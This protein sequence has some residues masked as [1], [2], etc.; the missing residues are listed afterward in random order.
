MIRLIIQY[1]DDKGYKDVSRT[2][3]AQSG[4]EL[5]SASLRIFE[6]ILLEGNFSKAEMMVRGLPMKE[7]VE[8][9]FAHVEYLIKRERFMETLMIE[10]NY[11][12][13]VK[14]LRNDIFA[15]VE[16]DDGSASASSAGSDGYTTFNDELKLLSSLLLSQQDDMLCKAGWM[17]ECAESRRKLLENVSCFVSCDHILPPHRLEHLVSQ[18]VSFQRQNNMFYIPQ[19]VNTIS[20]YQDLKS[21]SSWFPS[22]VVREL[23]HHTNEVWFVKFSNSGRYLCSTSLDCQVLIYDVENDFQ[24]VQQLVGSEKAV[25]YASWSPDDSLILTC[26]LDL[27]IRMWDAASGEIVKTLNFETPLRVWT[28]EWLP[29]SSGFITGSPDK[30]LVLFNNKGEEIYNWNVDQRINDLCVSPNGQKLFTI[31]HDHNIY[32][33]CLRSKKILKVIKVGKKLTSITC[34]RD[35][36]EVLVSVSPEELQLWNVENFT[37]TCKFYGQQQ[38]RFIIRSCFGNWDES[39]VLSGSEDGRIYIWNKKFGNLLTALE[40]HQGLVNCVDWNKAG[41][42]SNGLT[43]ASAGDDNT[44]KIWGV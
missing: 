28:C 13:A 26:G 36:R 2:L 23:N 24:I 9:N 33:W 1:L 22:R 6:K 10:K 11:T 12:K 41:K 3:S 34:S 31:N 16:G 20:L 15:D 37:L 30:K 44:V 8:P 4:V 29:D 32:V 35:S 17:G 43:F 39:F 5:T 18:A 42:G 27:K 14:I 19:E 21:D 40:G 7:P 25:L 38:P